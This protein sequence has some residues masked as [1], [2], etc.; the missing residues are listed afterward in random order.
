MAESWLFIDDHTRLVPETTDDVLEEGTEVLVRVHPQAV[1]STRSTPCVVHRPSSN[2][3]SGW[4]LLW[5]SDRGI[6]ERICP[7]GTGH[8]DPDQFGFWEET[9]QEWQGVHGCDGCCSVPE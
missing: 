1:C 5:R 7:H 2:H 8:P 3:M 4:Y 6:F 9:D